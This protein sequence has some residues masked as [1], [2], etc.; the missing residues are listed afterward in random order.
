[1]SGL[2]VEDLG[3]LLVDF[4]GLFAFPCIRPEGVV[5]F[6]VPWGK[7]RLLFL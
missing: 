4:V 2:G 1:M 6:S 3:F 5:L 7:V